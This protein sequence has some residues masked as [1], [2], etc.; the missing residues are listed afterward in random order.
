MIWDLRT[1]DS[2]RNYTQRVLVDKAAIR[3]TDNSMLGVAV[4]KEAKSTFMKSTANRLGV[5]LHP[6]DVGGQI[7]DRFDE[8]G[9]AFD[10][11][12]DPDPIKV[13]LFLEGAEPKMQVVPKLQHHI[14]VIP[15]RASEMPG[16]SF[17]ES[18]Y[19]NIILRLSGWS[20]EE[21]CFIYKERS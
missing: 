4:F 3:S 10:V 18:L 8:D 12:W 11:Y 21:R 17:G 15:P 13:K 19:N 1:L 14:K 9:Y 5:R 16:E 6:D 7:S 2:V 20:E